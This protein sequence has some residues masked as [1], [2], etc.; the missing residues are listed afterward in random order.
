MA[1]ARDPKYTVVPQRQRLTERAHAKA[2]EA[3][4]RPAVVPPACSHRAF[5]RAGWLMVEQPG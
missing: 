3:A 1:P 4:P 2:G 5:R